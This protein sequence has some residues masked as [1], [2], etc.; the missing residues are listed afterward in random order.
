L[1]REMA[2]LA[3]SAASLADFILPVADKT[4]LM[5]ALKPLLPADDIINSQ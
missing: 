1:E 4:H 2:E 3:G 5:A